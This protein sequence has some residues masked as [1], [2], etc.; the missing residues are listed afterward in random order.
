MNNRLDGD[1]EFVMVD[2]P[3]ALPAKKQTKMRQLKNNVASF[4]SGKQSKGGKKRGDKD[5]KEAPLTLM[6]APEAE[7][8]IL[9]VILLVAQAQFDN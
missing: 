9:R 4:I 6:E 5:A 7:T 1:D 8:S 2:S 3:T